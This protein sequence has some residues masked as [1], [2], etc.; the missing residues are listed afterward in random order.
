[1]NMSPTLHRAYFR[2]RVDGSVLNG[3]ETGSGVAEVVKIRS[4]CEKGSRWSRA[5]FTSDDW[6]RTLT[7]SRRDGQWLLSIDGVPRTV[8]STWED[9]DDD[10]GN[11]LGA[12][13][14]QFCYWGDDTLGGI[15]YIYAGTNEC[16]AIIN[17][18]VNLPFSSNQV[19]TIALP[20]LGGPTETVRSP[21]GSG[22]LLFGDTYY[23]TSDVS[24]VQCN[25]FTYA[26]YLNVI[27]T[28]NGVQYRYLGFL[29]LKENTVENP[30][31]DG[32][33]D[34]YEDYSNIGQFCGNPAMD[35]LNSKFI[36]AHACFWNR[37]PSFIL[38][39]AHH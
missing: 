5:A 6:I 29:Q 12:G 2:T 33:G 1:M 26:D 20:N 17:P 35:F 4:P 32:G 39:F 16:F 24:S 13:S 21:R 10:S 34:M 9:E 28:R 37:I 8:V 14:W 18:P 7:A 22:E 19:K 15:I 27:G 31:P 23:A 25:G 36:D 11:S 38:Q 30:E 3:D